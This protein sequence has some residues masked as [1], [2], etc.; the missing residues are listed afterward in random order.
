MRELSKLNE[1][2]KLGK[3]HMFYSYIRIRKFTEAGLRESSKGCSVSS[4]EGALE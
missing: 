2:I 4:H 1:I 3:T